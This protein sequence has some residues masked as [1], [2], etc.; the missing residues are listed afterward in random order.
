MHKIAR[1]HY[2]IMCNLKF[3][4]CMTLNVSKNLKQW[5]GFAFSIREAIPLKLI[6]GLK[7]EGKSD[8]F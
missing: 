1:K 7:D 2:V 8:F 5:L 4:Q 3:Y 6:K